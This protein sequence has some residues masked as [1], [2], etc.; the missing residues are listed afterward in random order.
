MHNFDSKSCSIVNGILCTEPSQNK[1]QASKLLVNELPKNDQEGNTVAK[2]TNYDSPGSDEKQSSPQARG[3]D[4]LEDLKLLFLE[5]ELKELRRDVDSERKQNQYLAE[6]LR[7]TQQE[8]TTESLGNTSSSILKA[9]RSDVFDPNKSEGVDQKIWRMSDIVLPFGATLDPLLVHLPSQPPRPPTLRECQTIAR[10]L[11]QINNRQAH[12][13]N[14]LKT[15]LRDVLYSHKWT[16]DAY[17]LARAYVAD[18]EAAEAAQQPRRSLP[19]VPMKHLTKK[20]PD[21]AYAAQETVTLPPLKTIVG[22]QAIER[23]KRTQC[24]QKTKSAKHGL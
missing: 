15:D 12:E 18:D 11:Q 22:N 5:E 7:K 9:N 17:L 21:S 6:L 14:Q 3:S 20:L 23:Q 1:G 16:P 19:R 4:N 2:A 24:L 13:L 10:H 8:Q